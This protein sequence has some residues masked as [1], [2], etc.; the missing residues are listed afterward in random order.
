MLLRFCRK[1]IRDYYLQRVWNK[2]REYIEQINKKE[3][4]RKVAL[5]FSRRYRID[6]RN[7]RMLGRQRSM[8]EEL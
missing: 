6:V 4:K 2:L 8:Q 3:K 7:I 5:L 1:K